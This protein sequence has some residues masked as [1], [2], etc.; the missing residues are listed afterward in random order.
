MTQNNAAEL[1]ARL[2]ESRKH[3][4]VADRQRGSLLI[5]AR[6]YRW[7]SLACDQGAP[8][9]AV[10]AA[11]WPL[12]DE[13][14]LVP[15]LSQCNE[16][17]LTVALPRMQ[18]TD[19]PLQFYRWQD[20]MALVAGSFGVMEPAVGEPLLPDV[21]LVPTLGF[22]PDGDRLGYGKGF[23]DRTLAHLKSIKQSLTTIGVAW[24]CGDISAIDSHYRAQPHD[25]RL[26]AII[27]PTTWHPAAPK[28]QQMRLSPTD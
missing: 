26:D 7:L 21:V 23:Y 20:D 6:L 9:A 15:L 18:A 3:L 19:Q 16:A 5:R 4:A 22:T 2:K 24:D 10:I 11:Y 25:Q 17:G 1:R 12:P 8:T 28:P 14:D 27:T 13:P